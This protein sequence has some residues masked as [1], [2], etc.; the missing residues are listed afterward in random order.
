MSRALVIS[1]S[2]ISPSKTQTEVQLMATNTSHSNA[3][4]VAFLV[5]SIVGFK[6]QS[7]FDFIK[8][9]L[10]TFNNSCK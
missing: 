1:Y 3:N 7:N 4:G 9:I 6:Q 2:I 8:Y 10:I 5:V